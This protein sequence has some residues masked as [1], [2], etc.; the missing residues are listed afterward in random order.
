[1]SQTNSR[2]EQ[3]SY[4]DITQADID[5]TFKVLE[6]IRDV[7]AINSGAT[8]AA[9]NAHCLVQD[10]ED[11]VTTQPTGQKQTEIEINGVPQEAVD[12]ALDQLEASSLHNLIENN[13]AELVGELEPHPDNNSVVV[14]GRTLVEEQLRASVSEKIWDMVREVNNGERDDYTAAELE[15]ALRTLSFTIRQHRTTEQ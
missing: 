9:N 11:D 7:W 10:F 15:N 2:Q 4:S 13:D 1:M 8:Q 3:D 5:S 6:A 14:F 12:F